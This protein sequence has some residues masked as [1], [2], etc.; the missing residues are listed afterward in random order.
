MRCGLRP[1][2]VMAWQ[3]AVARLVVQVIATARCRMVRAGRKAACRLV[4]AGES[5]KTYPVACLTRRPVLPVLWGCAG[6]R[7]TDDHPQGSRRN[8]TAALILLAWQ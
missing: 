5:E 8:E 1:S 7:V 6:Q 2:A 3:S 4:S